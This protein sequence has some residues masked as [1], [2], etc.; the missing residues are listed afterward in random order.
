MLRAWNDAADPAV[1]D[2]YPYATTS[3]V[4]LELPAPR[5]AAGGDATYFADWLERIITATAAREDFND[6]RERSA[7]LEYLRSAQQRYRTL[8]GQNP[9]AHA[10]SA[11]N[12]LV[13]R[14]RRWASRP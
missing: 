1:L 9:E 5:P 2:L 14:Q 11:V 6:E 13:G 4:W 12:P 10:G 7:T 8:A 3:P